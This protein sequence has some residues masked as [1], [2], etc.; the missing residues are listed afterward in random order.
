MNTT[1]PYDAPESE[2]GAFD[3]TGFCLAYRLS[4]SM[5]YREIRD[6]RLRV[7]KVGNRTLISRRA[8]RDYELLCEKTQV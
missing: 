4:R 2:R 6:G 3:I 1:F 8:A 7:M 5:I